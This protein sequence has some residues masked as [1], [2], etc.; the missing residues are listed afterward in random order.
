M[1]WWTPASC[2]QGGLRGI[3]QWR[4]W[5]GQTPVLKYNCANTNTISQIHNYKEFLASGCELQHRHQCDIEAVQCTTEWC[6]QTLCCSGLV[7][8]EAKQPPTFKMQAC[9]NELHKEIQSHGK[10]AHRGDIFLRIS[11]L[12]LIYQP[13]GAFFARFFFVRVLSRCN[14]G[15]SGRS[16]ALTFL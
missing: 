12:D 6:S 10:Q 11:G 7:S 13:I 8:E 2:P 15:G 9:H 5:A 16:G 1:G 3:R 14:V 4:G